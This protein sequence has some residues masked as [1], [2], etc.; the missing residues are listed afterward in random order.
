MKLRYRI[1]LSVVVLLAIALALPIS[2]QQTRVA[3][4][5][6]AVDVALG[7]TMPV[8]PDVRTGV[9]ANGLTY[10][11]RANQ[12]PENRAELR[13]V[14]NAG[15]VLEDD[16][17][18][19]MAHLLEHMAFNGT[20]NFEKQELIEFMESIGMR[21]G[22]DVNAYTS[23]DETVYMLQVPTDNPEYISTAF[24]IME[25]WSRAVTLDGAEIDAERGV[26]MEEW[27]LGQGASARMNDQQLPII[28]K[29]SKY[30]DRLPIGTEDSIQAATHEAIRRFYE[31]WYRPDLMAVIAVGDFDPDV[32]EGLIRQHF[33]GLEPRED[34]R[35]R[36]MFEIP[37]QVGTDFAIATDPE[38]PNTSVAVYF[39]TDTDPQGTVGD[40]RRSLVEALYNGMLNARFQEITQQPDPPIVFGA[41]AKGAMVR[42]KGVYQLFAGVAPGGIER[43]LDTLLTEAARVD[44]F[45]FTQTELDRAKANVLRGIERA[46]DDRAN[47][48]SSGFVNEYTRAYLQGEPIP[49][50]E[51]EYEL[52]KRF[53]P[54][55]TLEEVNAIGRD[56][57]TDGN[58]VVLV[59]APEND[60]VAM[61]SEDAL[62]AVLDGAADKALTA[63]EDSV[64]DAPL[65]PVIPDP[66]SVVSTERIEE[67][68]IT[69]WTLSNGAK[70][71]LKPTD[72]RDDEIR[73]SGTSPGGT[74]LVSDEDYM[75][76]ATATAVMN[77]SG[78][79][80]FNLVDFQKKMAGVAASAGASIGELSEGLSGQ[81]SPKDLEALFQLIYLRFT[82][83]RVDPDAVQAYLDQGRAVLANQ[84][85]SPQFQ[86]AKRML[87]VRFQGHP[88]RQQQTAASL[89]EWDAQ[90]SYEFYR[91]RFADAGDFTF[92]FVGKFDL[93]TI[94][95]LVET[96][97]ASLPTTG[98][99]ETWRDVGARHVEGAVDEVVRAGI[100]PQSQ[101]RIYYTGPFE[102]QD[103]EQRVVLSAMGL[104]L[105]NRLRDTLREA[106]GGTYGVGVGAS[107]SWRPVEAY[108]VSISFGSDPERV[109][110]LVDAVFAEIAKLQEAAPDESEVADVRA[111]YLRTFETNQESNVFWLN[112]LTTAWVAGRDVRNILTYEEVVEG[113]TPEMIHEAAQKYLSTPKW[114]V[115]RC[116]R[117]RAAVVR[118]CRQ[119]LRS[120][121]RATSRPVRRR[122]GD[123]RQRR[124]EPGCR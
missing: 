70:V 33:E 31:D 21:L 30:A 3:D 117:R 87:E 62:L 44:Q 34:P 50:L 36:T 58:R 37:D 109:D 115:S 92:F 78:L 52:Y 86:F 1:H 2:A 100:E 116:C 38:A 66:G 68:D 47:R 123:C 97:L 20:E 84:E 107:S 89:D 39:R 83:P 25:D 99:E 59:N 45:G 65:L 90:R 72:L 18:R 51:Y 80:E 103:R 28:F 35:E 49:G 98:R 77:I 88:R 73:F 10:Y 17:Q 56:W 105:Q 64:S 101:T 13:L 57:I 42:T 11:V 41:S 15:S 124:P 113:I 27:R 111:N 119:V 118:N 19:G 53:I 110:E 96:Y 82:A 9:F 60:D 94:Q 75:I 4:P 7:A 16:D 5:Q 26:V 108:T 112:T 91:E 54:S 69:E 95:P 23:F 122:V 106:L 61:P 46:Y 93:E 74:S 67:L 81:A 29:D 55:I 71:V 104:V 79:G 43:G 24:Q 8:D 121:R 85:A 76:A 102:Q 22:P 48:R 40:Y 6:E 32:M 120:V 14:V 114:R 63:Y 12:R